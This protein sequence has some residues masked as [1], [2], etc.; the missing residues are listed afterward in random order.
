MAISLFSNNAFGFGSP[1]SGLEQTAINLQTG[2]LAW[3]RQTLDY[4]H[5][6]SWA[7][8]RV[9]D[10]KPN[11]MASAWGEIQLDSHPEIVEKVKPQLNKLRRL[12]RRGQKL[13][14]LYGG[15]IIVRYINTD[16]NWSSPINL[17][18]VKQV[19]W[20]R[21]YDKW[22]IYPNAEDI[23]INN[24]PEHPETY[25]Y[26]FMMDGQARTDIVHH[27]RIIRFRGATVPPQALVE[28]DY[29]ENSV[30]EVFLEPYLE[31]YNAKKNVG[32]ALKSFS[33]P[34][35]EKQGLLDIL[36][37]EYS[38]GVE[39]IKMRLQ[40]IFADLSSNKGLALDS[41]SEKI[42]F[43]D[44]TFSGLDNILLHLQ[45][46]MVA[47]SG[48][49][50]PQL[51]KEHPNGL[52]AT[53]ESERLAEAQELMSMQEDQ[54][55]ELIREDLK[56]ILAQYGI[57]EGWDWKWNST[58]QNTPSED[59]AIKEQQCNVDEKYIAM[60]VYSELEVRESRFGGSEYSNDMTLD[61]KLFEQSKEEKEEKENSTMELVNQNKEVVALNQSK[62]EEKE[63][64]KD[65]SEKFILPENDR[66][67]L[68]QSFYDEMLEGLEDLDDG[69]DE[70]E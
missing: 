38:K 41:E 60:G 9:C 66:E 54:W 42:S 34:V 59:M 53:G 51:L 69:D 5:A 11:L 65:A 21:V 33:L 56:Y 49:T 57:Y 30:L 14:N 16:T 52:S 55:G 35:I 25:R 44:R 24:D 70:D 23:T 67:V 31:Y 28:N 64:K 22:E 62:K 15:A 32:M 13:A 63:I 48:L 37:M 45:N 3:D 2:R 36:A 10:F 29:W 40:K 20:S 1:D 8:Q 68:P 46:E 12:Y 6:K 61:D 26:G 47:S 43:L 58:Y 27:S 18:S 4:L 50:K 19:D 39:T 17:E 7:C